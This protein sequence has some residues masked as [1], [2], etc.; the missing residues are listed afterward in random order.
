MPTTCSINKNSHRYQALRAMS[1]ISEFSLDSMITLFQD[2]FGR[3][4]ELDEL[5]RVN[6]EPYLKEVLH[7]KTTKS[8]IGVDPEVL[9]DYTGASTI[10]EANHWLNNQYKD[11][12]ITL[13]EFQSFVA[14]EIKHRPSQY[15][16]QLDP[17]DVET[18]NDLIKNRIVFNQRLSQ[19]QKLYGIEI[20]PLET[21]D[22]AQMGIPNA[23][24]VKGFVRDNT[25]Y[26][27]TDIATLDTP[28]H[29]LL[30]IFLGATRYQDPQLY[31]KL[32]SSVETLP[33]YSE[34]AQE[35]K[36]RTKGDVNEEIFVQEFSKHLAG[37]PSMF[38]D[39]NKTDIS[40]IFYNVLRNIDTFI[41]GQYSVK[42][43]SNIFDKSVLELSKILGSTVVN[44][45][46]QGSLND[47]TIHRLLGNMKE[48]L[49]K[50]GLLEEVCNG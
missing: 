27:N 2:K 17:V 13:T 37:L 1:G 43:L 12:E 8:M 11:L 10:E 20:I 26:I 5:P 6:S 32:V 33:N 35:F 46:Q 45:Q 47:A 39:I 48:D 3:M 14:M 4:P 15:T 40:K 18:N 16:Q 29:E 41:S 7:A 28:I 30:H 44:N 49:F 25:I 42:S 50:R 24:V 23:G 38:D 31:F 21:R 36:N 22:I 9:L 19:M 34:F